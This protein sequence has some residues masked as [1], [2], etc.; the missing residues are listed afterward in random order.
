M[1]TNRHDEILHLSDHTAAADLVERNA[2]DRSVF[3][4]RENSRWPGSMFLP[5]EPRHRFRVFLTLR[6]TV[7]PAH[8]GSATLKGREPSGERVINQHH[9]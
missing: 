6:N 4:E 7:L 1:R 8:M 3:A 5:N 9:A 2:F